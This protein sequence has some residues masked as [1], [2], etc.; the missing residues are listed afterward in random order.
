MSTMRK[1]RRTMGTQDAIGGSQ[2]LRGK[3]SDMPDVPRRLIR[4][5]IRNHVEQKHADQGTGLSLDA[6]AQ[7]TEELIDA[8]A[9]KIVMEKSPASVAPDE[10]IPYRIVPTGNY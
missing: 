9:L 2:K 3:I 8:G 4:Y 6:A 7:A 1:I 5:L 10:D